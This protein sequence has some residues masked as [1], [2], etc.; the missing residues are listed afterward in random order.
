MSIRPSLQTVLIL[1]FALAF[2]ASAASAASRDATLEILNE[3]ES[4]HA[5]EAVR[6]VVNDGRGGALRIGDELRYRF[7]SETGGYLTAIH[8]DTHGAATLLYPRS[9]ARAGRLEPSGAISLPGEGDGFALTVQ[10]PVGRDVLIAIVTPVPVTRDALGIDAGD[11]VVAFE[12]HQGPDF[13]ARVRDHLSAHGGEAIEVAMIEQQVDGR[14]EVLYRS[15]DIVDFFGERTRSI[16]PPKLD[17]QI[18]FELDSAA[19]DDEARRNIDEFARA[20]ADPRMADMR[21]QVSGHTDDQ[22]TESH[23][24]ELSR[25]RAENV[26][27]YLVEE[28]GIEEDRLMIEAYGESQPLMPDRSAFARRMNRRVEFTPVR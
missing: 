9:D 25:R 19:L 17:L 11:L 5:S 6:I 2:V 26:R 16:R 18:Q 24:M 3:I 13:A 1:A 7:E 22:G 12:P 28:G 21:F 15:A 10:P 20:L 14:G 8:V 4:A 27:E 23:N